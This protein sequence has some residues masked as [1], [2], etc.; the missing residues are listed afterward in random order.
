MIV[1]VLL[2]LAPVLLVAWML[3]IRRTSAD[4][5]GC[6]G[7]LLAMLCAWIWFETAPSVIL[8]S[9]LTGVIGSLPIALVLTASIF[10]IAVMQQCG[11]LKR[12]VVFMKALTPGQQATQILLLNMGFGVLLTSLGAATVSIFPPIMLALGYTGFAAVLLPCLGYTAMCIYALLG[13]PAVVFASFAGISLSEAGWLFARYMPILSL[14]VGLSMLWVTGGL[15]LVKEGFLPTV[16][17]AVAGG[18]VCLL[19]AKAGLVTITGIVAGAAMIASLLGYTALRG[20]PVFDRSNLSAEDHA[21]EQQFSLVRACSPWLVLTGV[22]LIINA[23]FLPF[24]KITFIDLA[25]P[26]ELIPGAP[27]KI[28]LF[29]QAYF[30]VFVS[31]LVCLP[32]LRTSRARLCTAGLVFIKRGWRVFIS[33]SVFFALAYVMNHSGKNADW[34]LTVSTNNMINVLAGAAA[35]LFG[36]LYALAAP[37]L[38]LIAGFISGSQTSAIAMFTRLHLVTAD[39]LHLSGSLLAVASA[40]GGGLAGVISPAKIQS[41]AA[42]IDRPEEAVRVMPLAFAL[43]L[44]GA[45]ACAVLTWLWM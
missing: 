27:E 44:I 17:A 45:L 9:A 39:T 21:S 11:A 36:G 3:L 7:L 6:A 10:Q 34:T 1:S 2:A 42:S 16:C 18:A 5:A 22:S 20:K 24:L 13:I 31:T 32:F 35:G 30:W 40:M 19:L 23:P 28:R 26:V 8:Q 14:V 12:V 15:R 38:G 41:A 37:L 43:G 29:W 4:K 25:M 33:A